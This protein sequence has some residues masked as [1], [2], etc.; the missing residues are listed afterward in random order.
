[1]KAGSPSEAL[2]SQFLFPCVIGDRHPEF[3]NEALPTIE[4]HNQPLRLAKSEH[5]KEKCPGETSKENRQL[6][7]KYFLLSQEQSERF[8]SWRNIPL[9]ELA[10]EDDSPETLPE[11]SWRRIREAIFPGSGAQ[12]LRG[13]HFR[14]LAASVNRSVGNLSVEPGQAPLQNDEGYGSMVREKQP[15]EVPTEGLGKASVKESEQCIRDSTVDPDSMAASFTVSSIPAVNLDGWDKELA[16]KFCHDLCL[17]D[18]EFDSIRRLN[19][20]LLPPLHSFPLRLGLGDSSEAE[21][22]IMLFGYRR[23]SLPIPKP[24]PEITIPDTPKQD[25][26]SVLPDDATSKWKANIKSEG[27]LRVAQ[28]DLNHAKGRLAVIDQGRYREFILNSVAYKWLVA[29]LSRKLALDVVEVNLDVPSSIHQE[30]LDCYENSGHG[31]MKRPSQQYKMTFS[32]LWNPIEFLNQQ[33][34][35]QCDIGRLLGEILTLTGT[36][37]DAQILPCSEYLNQTWPTTGLAFLELLRKALVSQDPV[38]G[39][40]EDKTSVRCG[41][42]TLGLIAQVKGIADSIAII[43][44][45]IGWLGAALRSSCSDSG[46]STCQPRFKIFKAGTDEAECSFHFPTFPMDLTKYKPGQCWHAILRNP[47]IVEGYPIPRRKRYG[48][49]LEMPLNVMAGLNSSPRIHKYEGNYYLKGYST[50]LVPTEKIGNMVLWHLY[51]SDDGSR[52]P[53]PNPT[54]LQCTS[55]N[56]QDLTA[57]RHVVGWCSNAKFMTGAADMNYD[58]GASQLQRPG[59]EFALEKIS[60]SFGQFVTGGCQFAIGRKDRH[61]RATK[62][63]Y[64]DKLKWLD[65]KYVT[66]WD[67]DDERGWLVNG[68]GALL[69]L[70]R[71]SLQHSSTDKFSSDFHFRPQDF[72]ESKNPHS[73]DSALEVLRNSK[74]QQLELY[75][76]GTDIQ[77]GCVATSRTTVKDRVEE[78]YEVLEKLF[79][80]TVTSEASAKGLN[81]KSR[82]QDHL[83]GWDFTDI[84]TNRDPFFIKRTTLG[85][86]MLGWPDLVRANYAITLFGKGFGDLIEAVGTQPGGACK[87]WMTVPKNRNL[88]CQSIT[89]FKVSYLRSYGLVALRHAPETAMGFFCKHLAIWEPVVESISAG[90][91]HYFDADH[92]SGSCFVI[93]I[94]SSFLPG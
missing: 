2:R 33:F 29:R 83:E 27:V 92:Q 85:F 70:L 28:A 94:D 24:I 57:A 19:N 93:F 65:K 43:G 1:M 10:H 68:N 22:E 72:Q 62:G 60:F 40:L 31:G 80:Y 76:K 61:V 67:V 26:G 35:T 15:P 3:C 17:I 30:V 21:N 55:V 48:V 9:P 11:K 75:D 13:S 84:A 73:L 4:E 38:S 82:F 58:I 64:I 88:L 69:H 51:Y 50:A 79:D 90:R 34:G 36:A 20:A 78:L 46:F 54:G 89:L 18:P 52:L 77:Q 5:E 32:A 63:T 59:K 8:R 87:E 23:G 81:A 12:V 37:T 42:T 45:Q 39:K 91:E 25:D 74:N 49:G 66:L 47:V 86:S 16:E 6:R 56:I 41:F 53:Y 7:S 44:E 14:A 71:S